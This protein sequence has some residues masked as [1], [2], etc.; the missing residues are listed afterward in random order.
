MRTVKAFFAEIANVIVRA[1]K[2]FIVLGSF[3]AATLLCVGLADGIQ[4]DWGNIQ[5]T[6]GM[7]NATT[8]DNKDYSMGYKLYV[9]KSATQ[10]SPAPAVLCLHGYQNDHET[11]AGYALEIARHGYVALAIDEFGPWC[12]D[13]WH[14]RSRL[15]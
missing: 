15:G 6:S 4:K 2:P 10:G 12:D 9:P 5:V 13:N 7:I 1:K 8:V 3:F 11:S 14:R